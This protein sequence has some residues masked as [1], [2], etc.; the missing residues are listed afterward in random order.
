ME[1]LPDA[2]P[3]AAHDV[4]RRWYAGEHSG[5]PWTGMLIVAQRMAGQPV[6]DP[7]LAVK[8]ILLEALDT[9][10]RQG[11][12]DAAQILRWRFLDDLTAYDV[13]NRLNLSDNI[14]YKRQRAAIRDLAAI[15]WQAE[16]AAL[17][18]RATRIAARLE[19][20]EPSRLFGVAD[21]LTE[22]VAVLTTE[23]SPWLVAVVGIGGIGKTSLADAVVRVVAQTPTF[24]DVA[25]VSARQGRFTLWDGLLENPKGHP[26]LTFEGLLDA[27]VEQFGLQDLAQS[28]LAQKQARLSTRFKAHPYLVVIDNLEMA[29]DYRALVPNLKALINPSKFLLTCRH[30]LHEHPGVRNL[31]LDELSG[32]DSLALLR[33]EA[34]ERGLADVAAASDETLLQVYEVTGGN[35]LA[36]KL[37]VGQMHTLSLLQVVEDLRRAR[38]QTVEDLYHHIY[39][40]AWH[41][42]TEETQRV[43]AIMP[44]VA[45]SGSG[46]E[47]ITALGGLADDQLTSALKELVTLSL[48]NV[49]GTVKARR[50]SIHRLTETFLLNEV[51]KWQTMC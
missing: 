23:G 33:H 37:L 27:V 49:R 8:E 4:L 38:G 2:L 19:I 16:K 40:R 31:N 32:Q 34:S 48:V 18:E 43:L 51:V 42:L 1:S 44:L 6:P 15:V 28:P 12:G 46:L 45:E 20:R 17:A 50:Y 41:L 47:Q 29:A 36:L 5:P 39:W 9:L 35:P 11:G 26:A 14:V 24:A 30:S 10:N 22:L 7:D 13:A 3:Q 21:K 25:W